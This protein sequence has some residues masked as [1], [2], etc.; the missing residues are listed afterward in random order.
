MQTRCL[1]VVLVFGVLG[2]HTL[3]VIKGEIKGGTPFRSQ[4][5]ASLACLVGGVVSQRLVR[6]SWLRPA[7]EKV[8]ENVSEKIPLFSWLH[9]WACRRTA[10][11]LFAAATAYKGTVLFWGRSGEFWFSAPS[12]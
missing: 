2:F 11:L 10:G 4:R 12:P 9:Q 1:E 7:S 5:P 3:A 8:S 6:V